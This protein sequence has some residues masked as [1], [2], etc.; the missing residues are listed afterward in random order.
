MPVRTRCAP[1]WHSMV[2]PSNS[3]PQLVEKVLS[4]IEMFR[5]LSAI[6]RKLRWL[7]LG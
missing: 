4:V 7:T 1:N 3:V 2:V 5:H 6:I